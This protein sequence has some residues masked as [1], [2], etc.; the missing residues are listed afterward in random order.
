MR[1]VL[2]VF[3]E[4]MSNSESTLKSIS[5]VS[6]LFSVICV[7]LGMSGDDSFDNVS[8]SVLTRKEAASLNHGGGQLGSSSLI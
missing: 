8:N 4:S 5:L 2:L 6:E 1:S 3:S 7:V